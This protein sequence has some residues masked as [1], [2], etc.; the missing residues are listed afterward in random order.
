M[1]AKGGMKFWFT[2][3]TPKGVYDGKAPYDDTVEQVLRVAREMSTAAPA[4]VERDV[5]DFAKALR[6]QAEQSFAKAL[7]PQ[8]EPSPAAEPVAPV[9]FVEPVPFVITKPSVSRATRDEME[10][11]LANYRAFQ[12]RLNDER[13]ARIRRTMDDVREQLKK[14]PQDSSLH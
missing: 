3:K 8:A 10:R 12:K 1:I 2:K 14:P 4:E 5:F 6:P 11:R 9:P 7:G 13:E